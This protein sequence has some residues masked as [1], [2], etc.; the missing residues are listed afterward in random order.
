MATKTPG[1]SGFDGSS[2]SGLGYADT[3]IRAAIKLCWIMMPPSK[4]TAD[5]AE[6]AF[7][8]LVDRAFRD[9]REDEQLFGRPQSDDE[10]HDAR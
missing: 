4:R 10:P 7:R 1:D 5:E 9:L 3:T 6:A 2:A 8:H